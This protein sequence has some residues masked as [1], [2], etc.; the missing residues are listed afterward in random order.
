L[1]PIEA[2]R[3]SK[4]NPK[5]CVEVSKH[6][7]SQIGVHLVYPNHVRAD[8]AQAGPSAASRGRIAILQNPKRRA[9][10]KKKEKKDKTALL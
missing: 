1:Q 9:K 6:G 10:T 7:P 4:D 3:L 8:T 5:G 2:A